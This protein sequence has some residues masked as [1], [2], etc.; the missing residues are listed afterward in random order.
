MANNA[1]L[2]FLT[3]KEVLATLAS[4][5]VEAARSDFSCSGNS[6]AVYI[7]SEIYNKDANAQLRRDDINPTTEV[8]PKPAPV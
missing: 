5:C 8:N 2:Y 4:R 6:V 7:A 1:N 3:L